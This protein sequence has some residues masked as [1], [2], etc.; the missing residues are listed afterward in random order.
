M[1]ENWLRENYEVDQRAMAY[2]SSPSECGVDLPIEK[3]N[4]Y[5]TNARCAELRPLPLQS[6]RRN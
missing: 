4:E 3:V 6:H 1:V 2:Y 5:V